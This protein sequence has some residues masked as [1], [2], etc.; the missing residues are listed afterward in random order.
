MRNF[1][2]LALIGALSVGAIGCESGVPTGPGK[3]T[4]TE[5]TTSTSTTTT[6]TTT[7][8]VPGTS[9]F[10]FSPLSPVVGQVVSFDSAGSTAPPGRRIINFDWHFGD[11]ETGDGPAP[12]HAY[13][14]DGLY[15]VILLVEDDAG[16]S[17]R[18]SQP[19]NVRP[20]AP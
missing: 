12:S 16:G 2:L 1:Q 5:T 3:V 14:T 18:S 7:I 17:A 9:T 4:I 11:G 13:A 20:A 6:T 19:I 8:P 10:T 15:L